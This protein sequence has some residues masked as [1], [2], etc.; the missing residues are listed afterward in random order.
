MA[1]AT[2]DVE[3]LVA[4]QFTYVHPLAEEA[5]GERVQDVVVMV[6]AFYMQLEQDTIMDVVE[7]AGLRLLV[8]A[9]DGA[10]VVVNYTMMRQ[11]SADEPEQHIFYDAGLAEKYVAVHGH[12][13]LSCHS[14]GR[15]DK[16]TFSRTTPKLSSGVISPHKH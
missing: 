6:P 3:E 11:F 13:P 7:L 12:W 9:D 8:L 14:I 1:V 10:A 2:W 15:Q 16:C 4:M 5:A